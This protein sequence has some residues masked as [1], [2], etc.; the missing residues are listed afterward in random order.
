MSRYVIITNIWGKRSQTYRKFVWKESDSYSYPDFLEEEKYEFDSFDELK[1]FISFFEEIC[2]TFPKPNNIQE[3]RKNGHW[4]RWSNDQERLWGY[5]WGDRETRQIKF[6]GY[7]L[8]KYNPGTDK[9]ILLDILFTTEDDVP[10]DYKWDNGEYEG[11]L[12]F[13]YGDGKNAVGYVE[14]KKERQPRIDPKEEAI[15]NMAIENYEEAHEQ[16]GEY[17]QDAFDK[18]EDAERIKLLAERW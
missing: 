5:L 4:Q 1:S 2:N 15:V 17:L 13:K 12:Q 14:T 9:R 8:K 6:G 11:W 7:K 10:K 16:L 18:M 3:A